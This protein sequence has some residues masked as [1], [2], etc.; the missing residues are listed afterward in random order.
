[1]GGDFIQVNDVEAS[2]PPCIE[3]LIFTSS[4]IG[5][6]DPRGRGSPRILPR[7]EHQLGFDSG[8]RG[9]IALL[10]QLVTELQN[11]PARQYFKRSAG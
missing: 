3:L 5:Y 7:I 11:L 2:A 1:M 4:T 9:T 6:V 8:E 10:P